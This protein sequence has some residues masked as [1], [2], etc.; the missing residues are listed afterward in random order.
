LSTAIG[1]VQGLHAV[2]A[3]L[4]RQ[5]HWFVN[6]DDAKRYGQ[7][8]A[9]AARHFPV[10]AAQKTIDVTTL[11]LVAF[12]IEAPRISISMQIAKGLGRTAPAPAR[13][14]AQVFQFVPNPAQANPPPPQAASEPPRSVVDE[15]A[16]DPV[17]G[18]PA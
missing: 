17:E 6:D 3:G 18:S 1:L 14:P 4:T 8:M 15:P 5:P 10:A 11:I 2:V 16:S 9:N 13:G 12:S 7:A